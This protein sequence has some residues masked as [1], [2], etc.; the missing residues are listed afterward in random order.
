MVLY[1]HKVE[2]REEKD[3][4]TNWED[5]VNAADARYEQLRASNICGKCA[6]C[7][8]NGKPGDADFIGFCTY[9]NEFVDPEQNCGEIECEGFEL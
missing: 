6:K 3:M 5:Y 8:V 2:E 1:I 9:W 7:Y 4:V